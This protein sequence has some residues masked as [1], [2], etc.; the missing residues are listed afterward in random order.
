MTIDTETQPVPAWASFRRYT[1]MVDKL[2]HKVIDMRKLGPSLHDEIT[3][4]AVPH[5]KC[6]IS[7]EA[8]ADASVPEAVGFCTEEVTLT[9]VLCASERVL[10]GD[11]QRQEQKRDLFGALYGMKVSNVFANLPPPAK[12]PTYAPGKSTHHFT[13]RRL[14][15]PFGWLRHALAKALL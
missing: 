10:D 12:R 5:T 6:G 11:R 9:C 14:V 13:M 15:R 1:S 7:L 3:V 8:I 2:T 4:I